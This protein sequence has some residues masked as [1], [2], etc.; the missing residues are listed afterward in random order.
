MPA[1]MRS[2]VDLPAVDA[3]HADLGVRIE[4]QVDVLQNL[5]GRIGLGETLHVIDELT[6]HSALPSRNVGKIRR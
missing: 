1:M 3:E 4:R 5:A 6:G 2:K